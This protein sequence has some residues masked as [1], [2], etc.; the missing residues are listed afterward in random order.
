MKEEIKKRREQSKMAKTLKTEGL[1]T[2]K[3]WGTLDWSYW[4]ILNLNNMKMVLLIFWALFGVSITGFV[5]FTSP[6]CHNSRIANQKLYFF[7]LGTYEVVPL[8]TIVQTP[9]S[10]HVAAT[11]YSL[12]YSDSDFTKFDNRYY[13]QFGDNQQT[14]IFTRT[15]LENSAD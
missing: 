10:N 9:D 13:L 5:N 1:P 4:R 14:F 11:S 2:I 15:T 8:D 7:C 12:T 3:A 6:P